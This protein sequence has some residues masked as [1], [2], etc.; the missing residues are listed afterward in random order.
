MVSQLDDLALWSGLPIRKD[1]KWFLIFYP[2]EP[3]LS[4]VCN[5]TYDVGYIAGSKTPTD[6]QLYALKQT[7]HLPRRL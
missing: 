7:L 3:S 5:N 1:S 4:F 6:R 2:T